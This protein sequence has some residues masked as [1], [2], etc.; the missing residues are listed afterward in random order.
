MKYTVEHFD[1]I[2]SLEGTRTCLRKL[3]A[4][5]KTLTALDKF[6]Y[7]INKVLLA[8]IKSRIRS[9]ALASLSLFS[10][11]PKVKMAKNGGRRKAPRARDRDQGRRY[12]TVSRHLEPRMGS[13]SN[14]I[15]HSFEKYGTNGIIGKL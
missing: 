4:L 13:Q 11:R 10:R 12:T 8:P 9:A 7:E 1:E 14:R 2:I 3:D 5:K 15:N 6:K